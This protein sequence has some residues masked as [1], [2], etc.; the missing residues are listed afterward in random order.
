[1]D[2]AK[3]R[4][5]SGVGA[6]FFGLAGAVVMS[7]AAIVWLAELVGLPWATFYIG[8]FYT[9]VAGTLAIIFLRP[10][11]SSSDEVEELEHATADA[12]ADLPFDTLEAII[13]KR[14]IAAVG[15]AVAL[16][17]A[18]AKDPDGSMRNVQNALFKLI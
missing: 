14:P 16:G 6:A 8:M 2:K 7:V 13:K 1:M 17:Y 10:F 12:L 4:L 3:Y 11:K 9:L 15:L 18:G 5:V